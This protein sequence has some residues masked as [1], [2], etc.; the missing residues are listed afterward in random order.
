M[1][2]ST[3][4]ARRRELHGRV[5]ASGGSLTDAELAELHD[6]D[7]R[8]LAAVA[9]PTPA[10][11]TAPVEPAE[12]VVRGS[13]LPASDLEV[14]ANSDPRT[15][16]GREPSTAP[17]REAAQPARPRRRWMLPVIAVVAIL[18]GAALGR[19][20]LG[21]GADSPR[22]DAG[23]Q[24]IWAQLE[25]SGTY[26]PGSVSLVGSK[27]GADVWT[28][29]RVES[30][31][32]CMILTR[33]EDHTEACGLL[34]PEQGDSDLSTVLSYT[35]DGVEYG[36]YAT[37]SRDL[38]GNPLA[39]MQRQNQ[40]WDWRSMYTDAELAIASTLEAA[41]FEGESLIIVGYD[42]DVPVWLYER[43][44]YCV[45]I[46]RDGAVQQECAD[47]GNNS[48]QTTLVLD[49]GDAVYV[50]QPTENRGPVLTI[51]RTPDIAKE[52]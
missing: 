21:G 1:L 38:Q 51:T 7:N 31:V 41:G 3:E 10:E 22:L 45:M 33:G 34:E 30:D 39:F 14:A 23:Q 5:Y 43:D 37:I 15:E 2:D 24:K 11:P 20:V 36:L 47:V 19:F 26:T 17:S 13:Q 48:V 42:G 25:A 29:H 9:E 40:V 32:D 18:V 28:A 52:G 35:E 27:F 6:L 12:P 50:V 8:S 44:R 46:V 4:A 16:P 49:A